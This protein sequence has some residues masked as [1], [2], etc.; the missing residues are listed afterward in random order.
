M[1]ETP[2]PIVAHCGLV[3]SQCG[4]LRK[5][6]CQGCHS[7]KPM[8]GRCPVR[9]CTRERGCATCADCAEFADLHQC[10]KLNNW[11]AK[12]FGLIFR[13]DRIGNLERIRAQ[14]LDRFR[15]ESACSGQ[16]K[17]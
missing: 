17:G 8:F 4:S 16:P 1:S 11:I 3:C 7:E 14:G 6:K 2:T 15:A 13:S 5:G 10:R 12:I 9:R